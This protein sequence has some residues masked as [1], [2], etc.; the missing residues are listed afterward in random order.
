MVKLR[1]EI[2]EREKRMQRRFIL[3]FIVISS[4][5]ILMA[6]GDDP[7][8]D[9]TR[10]SFGEM[11][12]DESNPLAEDG[13]FDTYMAEKNAILKIEIHLD[14]PSNLA[15]NSININGTTYRQSR[16]EEES[17]NQL[18][19]FGFDVL[20]VPGERL[21]TLEGIEYTHPEDGVDEISV[22]TNN[23][24]EV[25]VL[26]SKPNVELNTISLSQESLNLNLTLRDSD[27]ILDEAQLVLYQNET[28]IETLPLS[29]GQITHT[30]S[31]L[32][33]DTNYSL[34]VLASFERGQGSLISDD[35]LIFEQTD[36]VTHAKIT[37]EVSLHLVEVDKNSIM[38]DY[39]VD[40]PDNTGS[41]N[42][43]EIYLDEVLIDTTIN[44][45]NVVFTELLSDN[46]YE[47]VGLY[48]YDLNDGEGTRSLETSL[49][50]TTEAKTSPTIN[51]DEVD[52]TSDQVSFNLI[53]DDPDDVLI[54]DK[55]EIV[56]RHDGDDYKTME[57]TLDE[58]DGLIFSDIFSN[59]E[60]T[61]HVYANYDLNDGEGVR[62]HQLLGSK[63][64]ETDQVTLP[65]I[66]VTYTATKTSFKWRID[67]SAL[68]DF[69]VEGTMKITI[70]DSEDNRLKQTRMM[71]E[72]IDFELHNLLADQTIRMII[73][74]DYDLGDGEGV[75]SGQIDI[76]KSGETPTT[77][78]TFTT[79]RN[80]RPNGL[81]QSVVLT[82]T[83]INFTVP[84]LNDPDNTAIEDSLTA[85]LYQ[86]DGAGNIELID[87][88]IV[89]PGE[90][91]FFHAPEEGYTY[92]IEL[93]V[94]YDLRDGDGIHTDHHL[95]T[96]QIAAIDAIE[97]NGDNND[98]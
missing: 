90:N 70:Y 32:L 14:N 69:V 98:E 94:D 82:E 84:N 10:P 48:S 31:E 42:H 8:D 17:T 12:V 28:L 37:P 71:R 63:D 56:L 9:V 24:F 68:Y 1:L 74:A 73:T 55:L 5:F 7:I 85:Y 45:D 79:L 25:Y 88:M 3:W 4:I 78:P 76:S 61:L 54:D 23:Q 97:D 21:Y 27:D 96:Y 34:R 50:V 66:N 26:E 39:D 62:T 29:S 15:I 41:F 67:A 33:S 47:L 49:T 40:D 20:R 60:F 80:L 52:G 57:T 59:T 81:I 91:T 13:S 36:I 95:G 51:I 6:C 64:F 58:L 43:F 87:T 86:D 75:Q 35:E 93:Y 83:V 11:R 2:K 72:T 89:V 44:L 46:T 18:I 38:I 65:E 22:Q 30:F 77:E 19:I 92:I 53:I 16:F